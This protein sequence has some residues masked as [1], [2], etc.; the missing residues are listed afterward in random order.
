MKTFLFEQYGYTSK[1]LQHNEFVVDNYVFKLLKVEVEEN[2][3]ANMEKYIEEIKNEFNNIG[4]FIIKNKYNK[5]ISYL[6]EEK[7]VLICVYNI[8]ITLDDLYRLYMKFYRNDEYLELDRLL[9]VTKERVDNIEK[10]LSSYLKMNNINYKENLN[11]SM[12]CVGLAINSMQYLSDIIYDYGN[13]LYGVSI[14]HKRIGDFNSFDFFNP[15]NFIVGN[16]CKDIALLYQ[17]D[18]I[19]VEDL[20][21]LIKKFNLDSK[22]VSFLLS[23]IMYRCDVFDFLEETKDIESS[24]DCIDLSIEKE[25]IKI[26][27]AYSLFKKYFNIRTIEWLED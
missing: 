24:N 6:L 1:L 2:V 13:K 18:M 20:D 5:Y 9:D 26:K 11:K 4:P 8:K 10:N 22:N 27:K 25:V 15:L 16:I 3:I 14:V 23:R 7:Y 17:R 21:L 19:T 12:F